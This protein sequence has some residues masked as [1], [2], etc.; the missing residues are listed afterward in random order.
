MKY[1]ILSGVC[2]VCISMHVKCTSKHRHQTLT[3]RQVAP[4]T[5]TVF[6][7]HAVS[8]D[9]VVKGCFRCAVVRLED[10][11]RLASV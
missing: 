7:P 10:K 3:A 5:P 4:V 1:I 6:H 11:S 8:R 9:A 2:I